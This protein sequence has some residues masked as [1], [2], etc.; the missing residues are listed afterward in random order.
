MRAEKRVRYGQK[1][2]AKLEKMLEDY[3]KSSEEVRE[4]INS[5]PKSGKTSLFSGFY[6]KMPMA[7]YFLSAE[8]DNMAVDVEG[9]PA[10]DVSV[11]ETNLDDKKVHKAT[12]LKN[13]H[14]NYPVWMS[15]RQIEKKKGQKKVQNKI[16]KRTKKKF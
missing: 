15:R 2:R 10:E 6:P 14:G 13:E 5:Q 11:M 12:S 4:P 9:G 1:E 3:K 7:R 16:K 8:G